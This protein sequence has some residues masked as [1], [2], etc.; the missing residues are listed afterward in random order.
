MPSM[1][2]NL[3]S[4]CCGVGLFVQGWYDYEDGIV[5]CSACGRPHTEDG[6]LIIPQVKYRADSQDRTPQQGIDIPRKGRE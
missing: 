3:K 4:Q 1:L 2:L 6:K 5:K